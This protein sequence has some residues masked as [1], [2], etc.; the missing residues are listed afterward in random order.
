M[1]ATSREDEATKGDEP[2]GGNAF[3]PSADLKP[4]SPKSHFRIKL[5]SRRQKHN[6][7]GNK[8]PTALG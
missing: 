1:E 4:S 7:Q 2:Q 8:P 5:L 3:I 6:P